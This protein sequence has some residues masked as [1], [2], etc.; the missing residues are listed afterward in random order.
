MYKNLAV[1]RCCAL[2]SSRKQFE[3]QITNNALTIKQNS[4]KITSTTFAHGLFD[5]S[6]SLF[7]L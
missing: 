6:I 3:L 4:G 7:I 1:N 5:C 2:S